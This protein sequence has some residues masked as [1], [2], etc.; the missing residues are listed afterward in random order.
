MS[1]MIET[2]DD[3]IGLAEAARVTGLSRK[4]W[5]NGGGGTWVVRRARLGR[6]VRVRRGD[7]KR[8][9][10]DRLGE[11]RRAEELHDAVGAATHGAGRW[12]PKGRRGDRRRTSERNGQ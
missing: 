8:F 12:T 7:V 10:E 1:F 9:V 2:D 4:T 11:S 5:A 6:A 3:L